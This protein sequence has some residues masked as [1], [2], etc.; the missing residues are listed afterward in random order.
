MAT[1]HPFNYL[2]MFRKRSGLSQQ[3]LALLL[4]CSSGSKVS[5]HEFGGREPS[6]ETVLLY[7]IVFHVALDQLFT[8][9][10]QRLT[11]Q[12]RKRAQ[13][14][15]RQLDAHPFTEAVNRKMNFLA[16]LIYSPPSKRP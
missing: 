10:H 8:E 2:K 15:H 4:G 11:A 13:R 1:E 9:E 14:L 16:N 12:V 7:K 3:E 6:F 5:R